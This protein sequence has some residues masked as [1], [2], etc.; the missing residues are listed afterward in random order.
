[1]AHM[2]ST[3]VKI[4]TDPACT[5]CNRAADQIASYINLHPK[6]NKPHTTY[7]RKVR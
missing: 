1:M 6:S 4:C 3:T 2:A 5:H 7:T